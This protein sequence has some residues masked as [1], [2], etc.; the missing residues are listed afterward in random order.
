MA[1]K[2]KYFFHGMPVKEYCLIKGIKYTTFLTRVER[3]WSIEKAVEQP[4]QCRE[5]HGKRYARIYRIWIAIKRRLFNDK[6]IN[7][8]IYGGKGI[9]I[10]ENWKKSF[11]EFYRWS[12]ENGYNDNLSI[13]R[14]DVNG[15]YC[16]ENC[17]WVDRHIQSANRNLLKSN[18]SGYTGISLCG[19]KYRAQINVNRK[20][21]H[22]G[23]YDNVKDALKARNEYIIKNNLTEYKIQ[24]YRE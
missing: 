20:Y 8:S 4:S 2:Y 6:N 1:R 23:M 5:E 9:R 7:Y 11:S 15:N 24:E 13:D 19:K 21:F 14:I 3:G 16:P 10:C 17:R 18:N 22:I 12:V